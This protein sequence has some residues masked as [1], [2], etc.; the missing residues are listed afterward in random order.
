MKKMYTIAIANIKNKHN[1]CDCEFKEIVK[2]SIK[3]DS[4]GNIL[5]IIY[6]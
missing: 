5:K 6:F 2:N 1:L 3:R 4:E